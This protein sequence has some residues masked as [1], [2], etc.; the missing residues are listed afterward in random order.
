MGLVASHLMSCAHLSLAIKSTLV[1]LETILDSTALSFSAEDFAQALS[2]HDYTFQVG[3]TVWGKA[4]NYDHDGVYVDIGGKATA[5]LPLREV[6]LQAKPDLSE[7]LPL[8]EDREFLIIRGQDAEGQVL[9]S[10]RKLE[11]KQLW[12]QL[13]TLQAE[14]QTLEVRVTGLNKGG[15][16]ADV[17]GLRGF[18]P[19][20]H[21]TERGDLA[22]LQG[23]L[24]TVSFLEVNPDRNKLVLS[25]RL[26][27]TST[28]M[29]ELELGQLVSGTI[30]SLKP[31]GAFVDL[32][33][34][35]GLLHIKEISQKYIGSLEETLAVGDSIKAVVLDLDPGRGRISLSTKVLENRP[36]EMLDQREQVM[37]EAEVRVRRYQE[38]LRQA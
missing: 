2:Q 5:F 8:Q 12:E 7:A 17:K 31:F 33:G 3:E 4:I 16:T 24:L 1:P 10:L 35:T 37:A 9:L 13:Q 21:L 15:V 30:A 28:R 26:A 32:Q 25:N 22:A 38:K 27:S 36:G 34:V 18:I 14:N 11:L 29:G 6:S 20:S 19:R 23:Q